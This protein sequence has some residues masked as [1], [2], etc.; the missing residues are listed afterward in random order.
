LTDGTEAITSGGTEGITTG[1]TDAITTAGTETIG[2]ASL[3]TGPCSVDGPTNLA[4]IAVDQSTVDLSWDWA[5]SGFLAYEIHG[6]TEARLVPSPATRFGEPVD[7]SDLRKA[8]LT[9][10]QCDTEYT[11]LVRVLT[12]SGTAD[13]PPIRVRTASCSQV[14]NLIPPSAPT[15]LSAVRASTSAVELEWSWDGTQFVRYDVYASREGSFEFNSATHR[16]D[17]ISTRNMTRASI[18]G[19]ECGTTYFAR[20][21]VTTETGVAQSPILEI[22]TADCPPNPVP[23]PQIEPVRIEAAESRSGTSVHLRWSKSPSASFREYVVD[24]STG[25]DFLPSATESR[26]VS[27]VDRTSLEWSELAC[28]TTY[29]VRVA[30]RGVDGESAVSAPATVQTPACSLP[31]PVR[32]STSGGDFSDLVTAFERINQDANAPANLRIELAPGIHSMGKDLWIG[33]SVVLVGGSQA[34]LRGR[35]VTQAPRIELIGVTIESTGKSAV[36]VPEGELLLQDCVIRSQTHPGVEVL[37]NG[38]LVMRNSTIHDCGSKGL[39]IR[40]NGRATVHGGSIEGNESGVDVGGQGR[41]ALHSTAVARSVQSGIYLHDGGSAIIDQGT[42]ISGNAFSGI[43]VATGA[44]L[45][46]RS[47]SV[48]ENQSAGIVV[49]AGGNATLRD[50]DLTGNAGGPVIEDPGSI[51]TR[52]GQVRTR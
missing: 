26:T 20:V 37:G 46:L 19:L 50:C 24:L 22:R 34:T 13:S 4:A 6:T 21:R 23:V 11:F 1:G 38:S 18:S 9:G 44:S 33:K 36:N 39:L 48:R 7:V 40:E 29:Y 52:E 25:A 17:P 49:E 3:Q 28:N 14:T 32:I 15:R 5:G 31:N 2:Q 43:L 51:V 42:V 27:A 47:A 10:L 16:S 45:D 30:V 41:L 12:R 8:P 35:I